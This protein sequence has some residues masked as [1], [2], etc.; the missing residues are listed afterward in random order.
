MA[1]LEPRNTPN[2]SSTLTVP[3]PDQPSSSYSLPQP[4]A[5]VPAPSSSE[6]GPSTPARL[7]SPEPSGARVPEPLMHKN[8][9]QEYAQRSNI[10]LPIYQTINEG[11]VHA[12]KFR[13]TV[14]VDGK[15][16]TSEN[17]FSARKAAEQDAAKLAYEHIVTNM[18]DE[19]LPDINILEKTMVFKSILYEYA[20]KMNLDKVT[21]RTDQLEGHPFFISSLVF[22]GKR[23]TGCPA[24][25]KKEAE[26]LAARTAILSILNDSM[27]GTRLSEIIKSKFKCCA[28]II[29]VKDSQHTS[30]LSH[31]GSS[32]NVSV[33][34]APLAAN[35]NENSKE[36]EVV[37]PEP[38]PRGHSPQ[39]EFQMSKQEKCPED[40][41][42]SN[43][44]QQAVAPQHIDDSSS[45]KKRKRNKKKANKKSLPD[46]LL[47]VAAYPL[48]QAPSPATLP[49][50]FSQPSCSV[51]Q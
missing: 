23:Y 29:N 17:V 15:H 27:S 20:A 8:R 25:T 51:A 1:A 9:L 47:P 19:G 21:Y 12:P 13:S 36:I 30:T 5:S 50:P 14:W 38:S 18:K 45:L 24:R 16:Y 40:S 41:K 43:L 6:P 28:A 11:V 35:N 26:Q 22:N 34:A 33:S 2:P 3:R 44:S 46:S 39:R 37:H 31:M 49:F 42:L 32:G 4:E 48:H 7:A 10:P